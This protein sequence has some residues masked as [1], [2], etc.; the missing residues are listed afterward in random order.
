MLFVQSIALVLIVVA[1]VAGVLG[2]ASISTLGRRKSFCF[3]VGTLIFVTTV[4]VANVPI[5]PG[6][7]RLNLSDVV[8]YVA[9]TSWGLV[10]FKRATWNAPE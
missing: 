5:K 7:V 3:L 1:G 2:A 9:W 8:F 10:W 4:V 6:I